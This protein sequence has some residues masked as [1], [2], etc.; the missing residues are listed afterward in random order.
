[1]EWI[2]CSER[3]PEES[4][5]LRILLWNGSYIRYGKWLSTDCSGKN[6]DWHDDYDNRIKGKKITHWMPLPEPP[7]E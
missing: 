3:L 2:K 7:T 6:C 5:H 4:S 1:M